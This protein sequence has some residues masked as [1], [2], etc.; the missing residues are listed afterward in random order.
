M[1]ILSAGG[2]APERRA[3]TREER[4]ALA[5]FAR[6]EIPLG[7]LKRR[8][9][10]MME[11]EFG[12]NERRLTSHFLLP[13]PGVRIDQDH[14]KK[15]MSKHARGEISTHE[16]AD[17]ATMLLLNDAYDCEGP[18]EEEIASWLND[19]SALTLTKTEDGPG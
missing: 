3:L 15:A 16:L 4:K 18:E 17:W 11:F 9:G 14:V 7:D 8:L 19:I 1:S 6:L 2:N 5:Q 10:K 13:Q 12:E